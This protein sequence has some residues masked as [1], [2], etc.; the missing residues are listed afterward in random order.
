[1]Q[2]FDN[3]FLNV[4]GRGNCDIAGVIDRALFKRGHAL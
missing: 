4:A 1:M 2:T 3:S